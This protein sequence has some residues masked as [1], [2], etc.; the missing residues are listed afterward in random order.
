MTFNK[1]ELDPARPLAML[2]FC[3]AYAPTPLRQH[4]IGDQ[5]ML[6]KDESQRMGLGAFKALGGVY[7]VARLIA[8]KAG[9]SSPEDMMGEKVKTAAGSMTFICASA[10][11]HGMAVAAGARLFGARARIHLAETVPLAFT[12]RLRSK[13]AEVV[14]SGA[15]YEDSLIAAMKDADETGG[16]H[17]ADGSWPGYTDFPTLI[18]EGYTVMAEEMRLE[19]EQNGN[20]PD[21]V[22][23]QAGV[24][25]LAAGVAAMIRKNWAV[26]PR[27]TVVEPVAAPCLKE[28]VQ[29]GRLT[30]VTGP[31]SNMGR[32]DCKEASLLAFAILKDAADDFVTVSDEEATA[33]ADR[34][35]SD[36]MPSTP[37][38]AAGLAA[39]MKEPNPP[40]NPLIILSEGAL[41]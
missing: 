37:S 33:A 36:G 7:A 41:S 32:L 24:G 15:T 34:I 16:I 3:P 28:S 8:D 35:T 9:V 38:G 6:I 25:G 12:D 21:H 40:E 5:S 31:E 13:G 17:L 14:R 4:R 26:Q 18:L 10:G 1:P 2:A 11:N 39:L 19:M 23:L 22:Y 27:I 29:K 30:P 20:W